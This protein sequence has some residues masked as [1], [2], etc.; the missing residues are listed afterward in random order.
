MCSSRWRGRLCRPRRA[1]LALA[2]LL[3]TACTGGESPPP[4]LASTP[5]P[6]PTPAATL[7][8]TLD[9]ARF[10]IHLGERL[11][12]TEELAVQSTEAGLVVYSELRTRWGVQRRS[13]LLSTGGSPLRYEL[14]ER[15]GGA[16]S[17]WVAE[18]SDDAVA[19]LADD[20]NLPMPVAYD[21]L[22]P[23]PT[24]LIEGRP[25]ALPY[26][27]LAWQQTGQPT[28]GQP[29]ELRL[30][31][32]TTPLPAAMP[33]QVG[34]EGVATG[35]V[36][37]A[38][39]YHGSAPGALNPEF[40]FWVRERTR[41]LMRVRVGDYRP[42]H[43]AALAWPELAAGGALTIE[44]VAELPAWTAPEPAG[45]RILFTD[46][47]GREREAWL[48]LPAGAGPHPAAVLLG[49]EGLRPPWQGGQA[50]V[51]AGWAVLSY[52]PRG[53]N[54]PDV[55]YVRGDLT[56]WAD[57]AALAAAAL[58]ARAD[59]ASGRIV[60]IG[61]REGALVAAQ[62]LAEAGAPLAGAVLLDP[63]V[64]ALFPDGVAWRN[65]HELA[66]ALGWEPD[67]VRAYGALTLDRGRDWLFGGTEELT[68]VGRRVDVTYLRTYNDVALPGLLAQ[69]DAPVLLLADPTGI[70]T[71]VDAPATLSAQLAASG[72]EQVD[73][74]PT[75]PALFDAH[76]EALSVAAADAIADWLQGLP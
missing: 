59:I 20:L 69:S 15:S 16:R 26:A 73:T 19:V 44:R 75:A 13:L 33:L 4:G 58:R 22:S 31:D 18:R 7:A 62:A 17:L 52:A 5:T 48:Q 71:A 46:A 51:D 64:G 50:L 63:P 56:A 23:A 72:R 34:S 25:S 27:L 1:A 10:A 9:G 61:W 76:S 6:R 53:L 42:G 35:E 49:P 3:L 65:E 39:G 38:E 14:E 74:N 70:W 29:P 2:V 55:R 40:D 36:I 8:D 47:L 45:E 60:A 43:S 67:Q 41:L 12:A 24:A 66:P 30:L 11:L 21:G 68:A 54:E 28:D 32:V 57:D 37:G